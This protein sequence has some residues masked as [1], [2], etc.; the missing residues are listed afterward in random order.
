MPALTVMVQLKKEEEAEEEEEEEEEEE[1]EE[2]ESFSHQGIQI[3]I[4]SPPLASMTF[5]SLILSE[6]QFPYLLYEG[7]GYYRVS[8]RNI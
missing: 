2:E 6:P 8:M 4:L 3:S 5:K 7:E 1:G